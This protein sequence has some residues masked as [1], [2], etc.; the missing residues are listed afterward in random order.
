MVAVHLG[1]LTVGSVTMPFRFEGQS[2]IEQA[3]EGMEELAKHV[4]ALMVINYEHLRETLPETDPEE[5]FAKADEALCTAVKNITDSKKATATKR[6]V[7]GKLVIERNGKFYN[8]TG[9]EVK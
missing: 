3:L 8:A 2:R 5:A 9:V 7:N 6:I 1:I 4:D